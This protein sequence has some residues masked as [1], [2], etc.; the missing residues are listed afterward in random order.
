[1]EIDM[2]VA[3]DFAGCSSDELKALLDGGTLTTTRSRAP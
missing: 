3:S 2:N 1:M